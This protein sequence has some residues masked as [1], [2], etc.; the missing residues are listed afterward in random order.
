MTDIL[1]AV[2]LTEDA[3]RP[4]GDVIATSGT[5]DMMINGGRCERFHNKARLDFTDGKAGI[6]L[7]RSNASALPYTLTLMERHPIGSQA[8]IPM[9]TAP[10]LVVVAEDDDGK[11]GRL[12]AFLAGA[13]QGVNYLANTWHAPLIALEDAAL[14]AVIDRIGTGINLQEVTLPSP[15]R[16]DVGDM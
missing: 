5:A 11:P 7:F 1:Q 15:I 9:G 8:F 12:H 3:F 4:F 2:P 10:Y 16:V 14:F 6:S 13:D